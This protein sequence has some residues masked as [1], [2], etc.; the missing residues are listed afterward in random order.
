M[1]VPCGRW[2]TWLQSLVTIGSISSKFFLC[3]MLHSPAVVVQNAEEKL[4]RNLAL[5]LGPTL[6]THRWRE[7]DEVHKRELWNLLINILAD[8]CTNYFTTQTLHEQTV[9]NQ[10]PIHAPMWWSCDVGSGAIHTLYIPWRSFRFVNSVVI[11]YTSFRAFSFEACKD[12]LSSMRHLA[13][14]FSPLL[15]D[16][17]FTPRL[18]NRAVH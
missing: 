1:W 4:L 11:L 15:C 16:R 3:Q 9:D 14:G 17:Q 13:L 7:G 10:S 5:L 18:G 2:T 12:D 6:Q 8:D